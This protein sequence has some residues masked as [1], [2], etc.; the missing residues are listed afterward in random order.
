MSG[1][2]S[3]TITLDQPEW[4]A[5]LMRQAPAARED[6]DRMRFA[7]RLAR[8]NVERA[9]GGGPFAAAIWREDSGDLVSVGVNS[10]LRSGHS[11]LHAEVLAIL[12]AEQTLGVHAFRAPGAPPVTLVTTCEPCVMC[13]GAVFWSG[14]RRLICGA[15]KDDAEAVGF[16]EGPVTEAS[17]H[18]LAA[19]GVEIHRAVLR[20]EARGVLERYRALGRPLY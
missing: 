19:H 12:F 3:S 14:V 20:Q 5:A 4:A 13:L 15:V 16:E 9:G 6:T 7:L 11:A 1:G 8:E 2:A 10:V 18:Y 17:Y